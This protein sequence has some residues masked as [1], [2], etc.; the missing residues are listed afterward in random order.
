MFSA[1]EIRTSCDQNFEKMNNL[2]SYSKVA[3]PLFYSTLFET[4]GGSR[5]IKN[6]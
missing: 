3:E 6:Q 2:N 1:G 4:P 5:T